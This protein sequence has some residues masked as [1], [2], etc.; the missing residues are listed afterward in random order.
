MQI[1]KSLNNN[2]V[3][4]RDKDGMEKICQGKGIGFQKKKG[5]I[6]KSTDSVE[7]V[8]VPENETDRRHFLELFSEIPDAYWGIAEK[9]VAFAREKYDI[10][11]S[12]R[13]ILP[14]CDHMAGSVERYGRGVGFSNPMLMDIK[15]VYSNE[16]Q[17]GKYAL[18]LL[19]DQFGLK[20][21]EDEAGF[22][23]YHFVVA[24]LGTREGISPDAITRLI[25]SVLDIVQ[26]SFQIRLN[27]E[28]WNYQ[29]FLTHLKFFATRIM[30]RSGHRGEADEELY[31]E[32]VQ[33]YRKVNLCVERI[34]DFILI[35]YH[36]DLSVDERL[37]LL[38]HVQRV[39]KRFL[40][41]RP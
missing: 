37:Y 22:L 24:Q 33:R 40:L 9:V 41:K 34:A 21:Q 11:V 29:R 31:E 13:I 12:D 39:T 15:R 3:L 6:L 36:Y 10:K 30:K 32:L 26:E 17:T 23:A 16:Y 28:D 18:E 25:A 7:R 19:E 5:D 27:E 2:M 20:M 38:I 4:V 14:L 1:I 8:F 35:D